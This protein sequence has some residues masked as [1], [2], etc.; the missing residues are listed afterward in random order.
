LDFLKFLL[1][2]GD[3]YLPWNRAK[4]LWDSLVGNRN[5][6][7]RDI[8]ICCK[9]FVENISDLDCE[10]GKSL[11]KERILKVNLVE[12]SV[13]MFK[14]FLAFMEL[15]NISEEK[16]KMSSTDAIVENLEL[17]GIDHLWKICLECKDQLVVDI[18]MTNLVNY[19]YLNVSSN[20]KQD[21]LHLHQRFLNHC[22]HRLEVVANIKGTEP[23]STT[24]TSGNKYIIIDRLL[25]LLHLYVSRVEVH[26]PFDPNTR[27]TH[28]EFYRG[29]PVQI[30][31]RLDGLEPEIS[32]LPANHSVGRLRMRLAAI[33][34]CHAD[35][36]QIFAHKL[37]SPQ[38]DRCS[39]EAAGF[40]ESQELVLKITNNSVAEQPTTKAEKSPVAALA[41]I[42]S[43]FYDQLFALT[44]YDQSDVTAS[45]RRILL[46]L[47]PDP[48]V[49][50]RLEAVYDDD[51]AV[52]TRR[53]RTT[54]IRQLFS[55]AEP[56][57]NLF[58]LRYNL[59]IL[60]G[61]LIRDSDDDDVDEDR[62]FARAFLRHDGLLIILQVLQHEVLAEDGCEDTKRG[63]YTIALAVAKYVL[64]CCS[65]DSDEERSPSLEASP[66]KRF[67]RDA[68]SMTTTSQ[69]SADASVTPIKRNRRSVSLS[70]DAGHVSR[71]CVQMMSKE[72]F[73]KLARCLRDVCWSA[74]RG[75]LGQLSITNDNFRPVDVTSDSA[76]CLQHRD[77]RYGPLRD[78]G[79]SIVARQALELLVACLHGRPLHIDAFLETPQT[80]DFLI[81]ILVRCNDTA[82]RRDAVD[83]FHELARSYSF[84]RHAP[85]WKLIQILA[86]TALP[87]WRSDTNLRTGGQR[88]VASCLEYFE[89][90]CRLLCDMIEADE[91]GADE[92]DTMDAELE[93]FEQWD[94][95]SDYES[96]TSRH[97]DSVLLT[98]HFRLISTLL[99]SHRIDKKQIGERIVERLLFFF[100]FPGA[101]FLMEVSGNF[102]TVDH[103]PTAF[104]PRCGTDESKNAA[105]RLLVELCRNCHDNFAKVTSLLIR[106]HHYFDPSKIK[107]FDHCP[108]VD[109]RPDHGLVG[110]CNAGATC[111]MN[112]VIQQLFM[113]NI[114]RKR[115]LAS[116][117]SETMDRGALYGLQTVFAHLRHSRLK[118]HQPVAFWNGFR[119]FD[120]PINLREQQDAFEFFTDLTDQVDEYLL[121]RKRENIFKSIFGG[122]FSD[123]KICEG[124][125]H[126]YEREEPFCALNLSVKCGSLKESLKNF[127]AGE[128]L[129]GD[130]AYKCEKCNKKRTT[131]KRTC[132]KSLP[133]VLV[134]QLK[135]FVYDWE[136]SRS[137]KFDQYFE[138]PLE[139]DMNPYL[140]DQLSTTNK[141]STTG[142]D[143]LYVL[144]GILVHSGQAQAGHY[145]S[146]I[147]DHRGSVHDNPTFGQWF[148]FNDVTVEPFDMTSQ[149]LKD[150]CF[151]GSF[152]ETTFDNDRI[153]Y[154]SAYLLFYQRKRD[155]KSTTNGDVAT[156]SPLRSNHMNK[157]SEILTT[158]T[159][160]TSP[161]GRHS[162]S[163]ISQLSNLL[164]KGEQ[165]GWFSSQMPSSMTQLV[166]E[167]NIHFMRDC[168]VYDAAY[169]RFLNQLTEVNLVSILPSTDQH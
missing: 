148:K 132:I 53:R 78:A 90:R 118:F 98:G 75:T 64:C 134:I 26:A 65:D 68:V 151:G 66:V 140:S 112:S 46:L 92:V 111:Y 86:K 107:E 10:S 127:V 52:E 18:A 71:T 143:D 15:V 80:N 74:S 156:R 47:P 76:L 144:V 160:T 34:S 97:L 43:N 116:D 142:D 85:C 44:D 167:E 31:S 58:R 169:F 110:L 103:S 1:D 8:I 33:Y 87:Y 146:F 125:P 16:I 123:Q 51:V 67:S 152:V 61:L 155:L 30:H 122:V 37:L 24:N 95:T 35:N 159:A 114:I 13:E 93:W 55:L 27:P 73:S 157:S 96:V 45:A 149:A 12:M 20:L 77:S 56:E 3:L 131:L 88:L 41:S 63:C 102:K 39:I 150:E 4:E 36:I 42:G 23:P 164:K 162:V 9:W 48:R 29:T 120:H 49:L 22:Y 62:D 168:G 40:A 100:L 115:V 153:R 139:L 57:M 128:K 91:E 130:N 11:F 99:T 59:E 101:H 113:I 19:S 94:M 2:K 161:N 166:Q 145:Y 69:P 60:S 147:R 38:F 108:L 79:E 50:R 135:R 81:D 165:R 54:S 28:G 106:M 82:I 138:F 72:D 84:V 83:R 124:C 141:S 14:C 70:P 126:R 154:W 117:V 89:L 104:T 158:S 25:S 6:T 5:T 105:F 121:S 137:L 133:Q 129:E 119:L 17:T 163:N 136:A 109:A 7:D 32:T 21:S